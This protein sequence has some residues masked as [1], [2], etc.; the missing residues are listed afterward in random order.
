MH[1]LCILPQVS[2]V[3]ARRSIKGFLI[4]EIHRIGT[5]LRQ[6]SQQYLLAMSSQHESA[7]NRYRHIDISGDARV[8]MG[9]V[10]NMPQGELDALQLVFDG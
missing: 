3:S 7:G 4:V 9:N 2:R 5:E 10:Y 8:H 1:I 6:N